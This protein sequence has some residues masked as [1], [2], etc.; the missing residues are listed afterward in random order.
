MTDTPQTAAA[1]FSLVGA[2]GVIWFIQ[3]IGSIITPLLWLR[4]GVNEEV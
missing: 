1:L 3:A 2:G 4:L